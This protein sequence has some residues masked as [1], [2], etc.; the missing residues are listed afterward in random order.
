MSMLYG[1]SPPVMTEA[2]TT[3]PD[4]RRPAVVLVSGGLD[5]ATCLALARAE[6]FD[7]Y[8]LSFQLRA[9]AQRRTG[10]RQLASRKAS[11]P[12]NTA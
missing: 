1:T 10:A 8:A 5:S 7:C 11:V 12:S 3:G 2:A 9:A 4:S 6:G